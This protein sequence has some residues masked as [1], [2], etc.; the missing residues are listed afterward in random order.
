MDQSRSA[1]VRNDHMPVAAVRS[2]RSR[3]IVCSMEEGWRKKAGLKD[4]RGKN[5]RTQNA[6]AVCSCAQCAVAAHT[7]PM[8]HDRKIFEDDR[9]VGMSC[10]DIAHSSECKGIWPVTESAGGK[11]V[12]RD[13]VFDLNEV[14]AVSYMVKRSHTIVKDMANE[15]GHKERRVHGKIGENSEDKQT[16]SESED[17]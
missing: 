14:K 12:R 9:F 11:T 15:Y 1:V 17:E 3:C 16:S 4:S 5:S 8:G 6:L 7:I 13:S 10:W 2:D